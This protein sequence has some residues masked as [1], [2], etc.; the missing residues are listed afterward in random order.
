MDT[1]IEQSEPGRKHSFNVLLPKRLKTDTDSALRFQLISL[2]NSE[3]ALVVHIRRIERELKRR[4]AHTQ[5]LG[6]PR[7]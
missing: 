3:A 2:K 7:D 6:H 1:P 5:I 4:G